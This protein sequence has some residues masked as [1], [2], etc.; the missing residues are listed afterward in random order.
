MAHKKGGGSTRN[1]RDSK[2]KRLG[3]KIYDTQIVSAGSILV[4]QGEL[5]LDLVTMSELEETI[6][7]IH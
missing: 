1:G 7:Y 6:L 3:V 4:R 5:K 2:S